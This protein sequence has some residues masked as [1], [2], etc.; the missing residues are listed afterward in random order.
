MKQLWRKLDDDLCYQAVSDFMKNGKFRRSDVLS[1]IE[2]WTGYSRYEVI[3]NDINNKAHAFKLRYEIMTERAMVL[4]EMIDDI[5]NDIDPEFDP[6]L[7]SKRPDGNTGKVRDIAYLCVRMQMLGHAL[8]LGLAPLFQARFLPFQN[9]SIPGRGPANLARQLKRKLDKLLGIQY[10][11]KTDCTSAYKSTMYTR[12]LAIM[13]RE[14]PRADWIHKSL[15][16]MEKYAPGG[17][18]IIGGYLDAFLFSFV[19]SYAMRY[20]LQQYYS[21]RGHQIPMIIC[22]YTYMDDCVMLGSSEKALD[23]AVRRCREWLMQSHAIRMRQTTGVIRLWSIADEKAHK[24]RS[25]PAARGCPMIDIAGFRVSRTHITLR[26]RNNRRCIRSLTRSWNRYQR[27]G[28]IKHQQANS[29]ISRN[30]MMRVADCYRMREKYHLE[31]LLVIARK[32]K[33]FWSKAEN[34]RRERGMQHVLERY[35]RYCKTGFGIDVC[36]A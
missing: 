34:T 22:M 13:I 17:H 2:E 20:V 3:D 33:S 32:I 7:L 11:V 12:I 6:V 9:A 4:R 35:R 28:T 29:I 15:M 26:K 1:D 21:R 14:I 30:G 5:C 8:R 36:V 24:S 23:L 10:F 19:M 16:L 27:T 18:L 25:S 31:Q